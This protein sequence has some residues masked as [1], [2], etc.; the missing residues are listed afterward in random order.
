[1]PKET[2]NNNFSDTATTKKATEATLDMAKDWSESE[3]T[4]H[5]AIIAYEEV[6]RAA[7]ES[8]LADRARAALLKIAEDWKKKGKKYAAARLYKKLMV[9]K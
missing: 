8:H 4:I 5:H 1:M 7:P 6:I 3:V 9:G 2:N